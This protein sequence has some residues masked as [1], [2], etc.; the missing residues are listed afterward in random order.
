MTEAVHF[1]HAKPASTEPKSIQGEQ[2][3]REAVAL[4]ATEAEV[5]HYVEAQ[6]PGVV[7]CRERGRHDYPS[8]RE[9]GMH[10]TD[11]DRETGFYVRRER[12]RSC[13]LVDRVELW[14]VRHK[15]DRI[16][17]CEFVSAKPDYSPRGPEGERYQA[18]A[19]N[20]RMKP[21]QVRNVVATGVLKGQSFTDLRKE[22][23]RAQKARREVT[24]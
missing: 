23:R 19:G 12:C 11:I 7:T 2:Q 22:I 13:G 6:S 3:E 5:E 21:R 10:F 18:P 8:A 1:L 9:T 24:E 15:G 14:D 20:G 16:L 4:Y 17:K